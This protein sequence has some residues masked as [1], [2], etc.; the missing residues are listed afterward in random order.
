MNGEE[1]TVWLCLVDSRDIEKSVTFTIPSWGFS[2][3][4]NLRRVVRVR[5][6]LDVGGGVQVLALQ[7]SVEDVERVK[8]GHPLKQ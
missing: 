3:D 2:E 7:V 6:G 8:E 1:L 4:T 5:L